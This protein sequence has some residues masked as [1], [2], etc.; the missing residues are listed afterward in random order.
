MILFWLLLAGLVLH[1]QLPVLVAVTLFAIGRWGFWWGCGVSTAA[2][3]AAL[4]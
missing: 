1:S 4:V 2:L 3:I